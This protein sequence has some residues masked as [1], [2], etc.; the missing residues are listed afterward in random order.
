MLRMKRERRGA[1]LRKSAQY[2]M[3]VSLLTGSSSGKGTCRLSRVLT[4]T[5]GSRSRPPNK[6]N[7]RI[8]SVEKTRG[9]VV[10]VV[11]VVIIMV[12]IVIVMKIF[13]NM[14]KCENDR[15]YCN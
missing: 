5:E 9:V 6:P 4:A 3:R 12:V 10:L 8:W 1:D 15:K 2:C 7:E 13:T 11:K 14:N